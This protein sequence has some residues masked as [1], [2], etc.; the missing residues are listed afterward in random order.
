MHIIDLDKLDEYKNS[1]NKSFV[2]QGRQME[3][4]EQIKD[5]KAIDINGKQ[6]TLKSSTFVSEPALNFVMKIL[7]HHMYPFNSLPYRN[8]TEYF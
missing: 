8:G 4:L 6:L 7:S 2:L 5:K 3:I 1:S